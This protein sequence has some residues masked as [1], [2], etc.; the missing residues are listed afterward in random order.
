MKIQ[1]ETNNIVSISFTYEELFII[2]NCVA[3]ADDRLSDVD[4]TEI[5]GV[6]RAQLKEIRREL[7][8]IKLAMEQ[9]TL[10]N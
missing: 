10:P 4:V 8:A 2:L 6:E 7:R 5:L 1:S 3:E 9:Q